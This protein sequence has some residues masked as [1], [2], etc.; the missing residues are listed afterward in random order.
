MSLVAQ[1]AFLVSFPVAAS[2]VGALV[3]T[4]RPPGPRMVSGVQHFAAGVVTAALVGEI[5]PELRA[6]GHLGATVLGFVAGAILVLGLGAYGRHTEAHAAGVIPPHPPRWGSLRRQTIAAATA[7]ALPIGMLGA[8]AVDLLLDGVLVGLGARL[9]STQGII[10]TVALTLEIL[11]LGLSVV[12]ELTEAGLGKG[13]SVLVCTGLG[14]TTAVGAIGAALF[15][16]AVS[17]TVMSAVLAFGAAALLYLVV[18]ELLVEAHEERESVWLGAM[19]FLG[20]LVIY[21]L[22]DLGG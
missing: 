7:T 12:S 9:G 6:E 17:T 21:V 18:E 2:T 4:I 15:L 1:A 8:V 16:G 19:F 22:A 5:M 11:F 13:R 20:F 14:L 10:L 3:A